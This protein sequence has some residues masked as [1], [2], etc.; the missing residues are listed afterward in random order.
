MMQPG[1]TFLW[2]RDSATARVLLAAA[3]EVGLDAYVVR[4]TDTGFIV[5]DA[6]ANQA[7]ERLA[8][9]PAPPADPS[10]HF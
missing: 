1:E 9:E 2:G 8:A 10:T 7:A 5:P 4:T 3:E 6:V